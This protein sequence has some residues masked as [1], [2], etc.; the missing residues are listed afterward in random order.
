MVTVHLICGSAGAGKTMYA[1]ALAKRIGAVRFSTDEWMAVLFRADRPHPLPLAWILERIERCELQMWM[2]A[3]SLVARGIDVILD[4]APSNR[5]YRDRMRG[6]VA[7]TRAQSKLHYLDVSRET[8]RA[9]VLERT[10]QLAPTSSVE[11]DETSFDLMD[12]WFEPPSD[13]ELYGA[14]IV[15]ED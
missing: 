6:R 12:Q 9:R 8:R 14:M 2:V 13:D 1:M 5:D 15:C 10:R 4:L 7:Q 3:E 11:D